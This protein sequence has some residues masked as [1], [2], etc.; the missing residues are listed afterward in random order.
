MFRMLRKLLVKAMAA[1]GRFGAGQASI[2]GGFE[3]KVPDELM[4]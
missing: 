4:H 2:H 3:P 1:Y